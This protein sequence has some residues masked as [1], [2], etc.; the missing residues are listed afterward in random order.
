MRNLLA[1][2]GRLL[3]SMRTVWEYCSKAG[4]L[5]A[6]TFLAPFAGGGATLPDETPEGLPGPTSAVQDGLAN[7]RR[8]AGAMA[9]DRVTAADLANV[10]DSRIEWLAAMDRGM[11]A[12]VLCAD[13]AALKAHLT[14][15]NAI[16]GVLAADRDS[17][18]AYRNS[19]SVNMTDD[20][21][22]PEMAYAA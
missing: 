16:R 7:I 10:P 4:R 1:A 20:E 19:M 3:S 5:V 18:T 13:D 11:L 6:R 8:L 2:I 17:V 9:A 12:K 22:A 21:P 15:R 14:G